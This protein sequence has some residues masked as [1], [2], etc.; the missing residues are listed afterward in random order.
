MDRAGERFASWQEGIAVRREA[1]LTLFFAPA[2]GDSA[3]PGPG[4]LPGRPDVAAI[5]ALAAASGAA[6]SFGISHEPQ[7]HPYWVELLALG[8]TFDL[9]GL[10]PGIEAPVALPHHAFGLARPESRQFEAIVLRPGPHLSSAAA[11]LPV[12]RTMAA[13]GCELAA[14]PG[15]VGIGWEPAGTIMAPDY[16]RST[17]GA[18]LNNGP[19]PALGLTALSRS[20][21]GAMRSIGLGFFLGHEMELAARPGESAGDAAR[22]AVRL[23][24]DLV[25]NGSYAPG[26]HPGPGGETLHCSFNTDLSLLHI[27]RGD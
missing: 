27:R 15:L 18:W 12:V 24:H 19:F 5:A 26:D 22:Q 20:P 9:R 23:I 11:L 4:R 2:S 3:A 7:D 14:L 16:F 21:Q 6:V 1:G 8:L 13:L 10:A 17:V 25:Q